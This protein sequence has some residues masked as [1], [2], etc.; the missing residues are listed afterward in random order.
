MNAT[1][2]PLV[3]SDRRGR[4]RY[5]PEQTVAPVYRSALEAVVRLAVVGK[6]AD[7]VHGVLE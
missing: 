7:A 2:G 6:I 5:A 1:H 4:L 3:R